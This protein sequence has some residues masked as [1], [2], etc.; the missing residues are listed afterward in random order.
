MAQ[1]IALHLNKDIKV[2]V[3]DPDAADR[4]NGIYRYQRHIYDATRKWFL[5]GRG[6]LISR[7]DIAPGSRV[8]EVGCG[9][10]RNLRAIAVFW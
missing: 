8:L 9:T 3:N 1:E 6:R 10:G 5:L 4:M 7:L 2:S